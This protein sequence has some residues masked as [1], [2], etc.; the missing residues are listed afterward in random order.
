MTG[1]DLAGRSTPLFL[2]ISIKFKIPLNK[3]WTSFRYPSDNLFLGGADKV[4]ASSTLLE[5]GGKCLLM[6]VSIHPY[7]KA[8][9][10]ALSKGN[11]TNRRG[12]VMVS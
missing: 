5:M 8:R 11:S 9:G 6:D 7:P 3:F 2:E 10:H 1:R 4:G 12:A